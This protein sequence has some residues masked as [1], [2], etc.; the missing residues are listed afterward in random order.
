[1]E[2]CS[3]SA[4]DSNLVAFKNS[5]PDDVKLALVGNPTL[6]TETTLDGVEIWATSNQGDAEAQHYLLPRI[7]L[8]TIDMGVS[9]N[10]VDAEDSGHSF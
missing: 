9:S 10:I 2:L 4:I 3:N 7:C 8:K 5:I 1:M 6:P